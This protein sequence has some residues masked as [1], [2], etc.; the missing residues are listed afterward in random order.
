MTSGLCADDV[1]VRI[2]TPQIIT[3]QTLVA[4][5][6]GGAGARVAASSAAVELGRRLLVAA[7]AGDTQLVLDLMAKGAPFT[8]DWLG[9]SALHLAAGGAHAGTCAVLLRA[10][11]SR[12][13]RSKVERTPLHLAAGAGHA[14][15]AR[16]LLDAGAAV[17]ARDMLRMTPLHWAVQNG[18]AAAAAE[19][20]RAGADPTLRNKFRKS[21][22][23]LAR[24]LRRADLVRLLEDALRQRE[25]ARSVSALV[26]EQM[27]EVSTAE[28]EIETFDAVQRIQ[29]MKLPRPKQN[30]KAVK[31]ESKMEG[32][33]DGAGGGGGAG[34]AGGGADGAGELLRRHGITLLPAD[35]GGTVLSAL[36]CGRTVVLSDAGKLMLKESSESPS[37]AS[38]KAGTASSQPK[39]VVLTAT[40]VKSPPKPG[41]KIFT[42]NNKLLAVPKDNKIPVKKIIN[43]QDM[44]VKFVQL[45]PDAKLVS[46]SKIVPMK[47]KSRMAVRQGGTSPSARPAV[48]IIMNKSN[49]HR[50]LATA[51]AT[52]VSTNAA[53]VADS[54]LAEGEEELALT[55]DAAPADTSDADSPAA[56]RAQL[57]AATRA[58]AAA[59]RDLRLARAR[60]AHYERLHDL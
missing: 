52:Q 25:A 46:P 23:E 59:R 13:A 12:D 40:P 4:G 36:Q 48:K 20:L 43:P 16:L 33:A 37:P 44:Q 35:P 27:A 42:L 55:E 54:D 32:A 29:D 5:G 6:A 49:F 8:T 28:P 56:L 1:V 11:V 41:V 7:R 15:V 47:A 17:D 21:P 3:S 31:E 51:G 58:L 57:A 45:P 50:L 38:N 39:G 34:G 10:G 18:H 2:T 19:L 30:D 26:D 53:A 14:A 22:L 24:R 9:T 60:L